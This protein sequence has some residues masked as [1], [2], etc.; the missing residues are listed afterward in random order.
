MSDWYFSSCAV[1]RDPTTKV[2]SL[3]DMDAGNGVINAGDMVD[4]GEDLRLHKV[5]GPTLILY[6]A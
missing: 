2:D 6:Q 5:T 3:S 4:A 1:D